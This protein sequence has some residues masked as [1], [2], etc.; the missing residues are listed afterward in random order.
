[1]T[2]WQKAGSCL[3]LLV[4][5]AGFLAPAKAAEPDCTQDGHQLEVVREILSEDGHE[6]N[7]E[8]RCV[9]CGETFVQTMEFLEHQW[10]EWRVERQPTCQQEGLQTRTCHT[11]GGHS[12]SQ[13]IP[14][15]GH[16][17]VKTVQQATCER[18]GKEIYACRHCGDTYETVVEDKKDHQYTDE[19][20][21]PAECDIPGKRVFTCLFCGDSYDEPISSTGHA[22]GAW[23]VVEAALPGEEGVET[24]I[25]ENCGETQTRGVEALPVPAPPVEK[26]PFWGPVEVAVTSANLIVGIIFFLVLSGE[27]KFL[28][29]RRKRIAEILKKRREEEHDGYE[30]L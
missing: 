3:L 18:K 22:Y 30:P 2:A 10:D 23:E 16:E 13:T 24:R 15:I 8:Y 11:G 20:E 21:K 25:C 9:V 29:W 17:Y 12:E 26:E 1:M 14:A 5:V 27:I 6:K 4:L 19:I 28:L 7:V